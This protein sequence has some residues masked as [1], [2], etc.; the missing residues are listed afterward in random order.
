LTSPVASRAAPSAADPGRY[1]AFL[2]YA[3]QDAGFAV[4][5][6]RAE[7]EARGKRVWVDVEDI[8][9]GAK[10]RERV[11]R[12]IEACKALIFVVSPASVASEPCRQELEEAHALNKLIIPVVYGD[13]EDDEVPRP[14]AESEWLFLRATD[15]FAVGMERLVDALEADLDWRDQ[16]TR[17]AGRTR[18][19][20]DSRRDSS[21]LL[22]GSDLREAEGW[23]TQ[24]AEHRVSPT[25]EQAEYITRSRQAASRR[26]RAVFGGVAAALVVSSALT[27]FALIQRHN[28][29]AQGNRTQSEL[30]ASRALDARGSDLQLASLYALEAYRLSPTFEARSAIL[31]V[32]DTQELGAPLAGHTGYVSS[33]A[34]SPDGRT[35]ASASAD[36]TV[37][38]WDAQAHRQLGAPLTGHTDTVDAIAFSPDG[39]TLASGGDD[40]TIRFWDAS[41]HR[42]LGAPLQPT[43]TTSDGTYSY[44]VKAVAFSPDGRMLATGGDDHL[45]RLWDVHSHH[46]ISAPLAGARAGVESVAFGR[47]GRTLA[48]GSNDSTVRI[49][50]VATHREIGAPYKYTGPVAAVAL[51]PDGST[52]AVGGAG[53]TNEDV[54]LWDVRTHRRAAALRGHS[55]IIRGLAFT[56]DGAVLASGSQDKTLRLWDVRD[57]RALGPPITGS[58]PILGIALRSDDRVVATAD[59]DAKVRLW[60]RQSDRELG[61]PLADPSQ[62]LRGIA[63]SPDGRTIASASDEGAELWGT[64]S[65]QQIGTA[66]GATLPRRDRAMVNVAFS[67]DGRTL[68]TGG[69]DGSVGLWDVRS[70]RNEVNFVG[71]GPAY[72][73]AFNRDGREL[74]AS[75]FGP[76]SS[77]VGARLWDRRSYK[78]IT[79]LVA[80]DSA[81]PINTA[82]FSPD[83]RLLAVSHA[84]GLV[85]LADGHSGRQLALITLPG[86]REAVGELSFSPDGRVLALASEDKTVRLVDVRTRR[87]IGDPLNVG[88]IVNNLAFSP[89]GRELATADADH[90]LRV[91]D[92]QAHREL[93]TPLM[94]G[95]VI[96]G[97]AFSPDGRV[98]A[99]TDS[100][101]H[102]WSNYPLNDYIRQICSYIDL[103]RAERIWRQAEPTVAYR[104]PC[105]GTV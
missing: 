11:R 33:V 4:D 97:V 43:T 89:D 52:L 68:A 42:E 99:A 25:T 84:S 34:F 53:V 70:R 71:P 64:H 20:L 10:W 31:S 36:H 14:A 91:W 48:A 103:R 46:Q 61:P 38:L 44:S 54:F 79:D 73:L 18:E 62:T 28:A 23:L 29:V 21:Y 69:K 15:D 13:V 35:L 81:D 78:V 57:R 37:R 26:Q 17:L 39:R 8:V 22:R 96:D 49:W 12:G 55:D 40:T 63:F 1:D 24:Q 56:A 82:T 105:P 75:D 3:R 5:R 101:L 72:D 50:D 59:Y 2:S 92:V 74:L 83:G 85:R 98:I 58:A 41:S 95:N 47:D 80:S 93:G 51:S 77:G 16:H 87:Q 7:L 65:R 45:V 100:T 90:S 9:G 86:L 30:L 67:P 104:Q 76:N 88:S 66:F 6:L 102:L 32:A 60:G 19:W 94:G 27:I